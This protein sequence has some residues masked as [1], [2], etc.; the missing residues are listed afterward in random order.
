MTTTLTKEAAK[1]KLSQ[2]INDFEKIDMRNDDFVEEDTKQKLIQ[3]FFE[4]FNWNF[5][6][7]GRESEVKY[8]GSLFDKK[9]KRLKRVDYIFG[10][11]HFF[12]EAKAV[13]KNVDHEIFLLQANAYAYSKSKFCVLTDLEDFRLIRP[14]KPN[15]K[16]PELCIVE[17]YS[18]NY[19]DYL[20]KFDFLYETFSKEK[21]YEGSL[22]KLLE[23]ELKSKRYFTVDEYFL[24]DLENWRK[25]LAFDIYKKNKKEIGED[26]ELLTECTQRIL[27]RIIFS[28]ILEDKNIES[29][30]LEKHADKKDIYKS[31]QYEYDRLRKIYNGLI[32]NP[33]L[34]VDNLKVGDDILKDIIKELYNYDENDFSYNFDIIPIEILGSVY[35]RF[36]GN[37]I[38][39]NDKNKKP[40]H[41]K[42]KPN[43]KKAGGVFYTP[44]KIVKY[45]VENTVG[46]LFAK[47]SLQEVKSYKILDISCGSGS[48]LVGAYDFLLEWYKEYYE[49]N[50][51]RINKDDC[52]K[53]KSHRKNLDGK[54]EEKEELKLTRKKR[55]EILVDH[56]YGVDIDPQAV[57]V[58]QMSLYI[59]MLD[60]CPDIQRLIDLKE[61]ILPDLKSNIK[62]GNSLVE[63]KEK[64][65]G[66]EKPFDWDE[67]FPDV[68][69]YSDNY[70]KKILKEG[71]GFDCII[72]NPP[73]RKGSETE[74]DI[75]TREWLAFRSI[76]KQS[77]IYETI[78]GRWDLYIPFIEKSILLLK[79]GGFH[80]FV[81]EHSIELTPFAH[82]IRELLCI[83]N[84]LE[85]HFFP[86]Q[87]L[88]KNAKVV[89]TVY[90]CQKGENKKEHLKRFLHTEKSF[91]SFNI[92]PTSKKMNADQVFNYNYRPHVINDSIPLGVVFCVCAGA[93]LQSHEGKYRDEFTKDDLISDIK[94]GDFNQKYLEGDEIKDFLFKTIRFVAFK[95]NIE[96]IKRPRFEQL[97]YSPKLLLGC[98]SGGIVDMEN[99][100]VNH[101]VIILK[102]WIELKGLNNRSLS[103]YDKYFTKYDFTRIDSEKLSADFD[104]F[105]ILS[106]LMSDFG[107]SV[108][109]SISKSSRTLT[110]DTLKDFPLIPITPENKILYD[111]LS[112]HGRE[113][114]EFV[115][116]LKNVHV[117]YKIND[118]NEKINLRK[119]KNEEL[120]SRLYNPE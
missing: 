16:R 74:T 70:G 64:L 69:Q 72:G 78:E 111:S 61:L 92:L 11:K 118:L 79:D 21:I 13:E 41:V 35:E 39:I 60:D 82:K 7:M 32:F 38:E 91:Y 103:K 97:F 43:V 98:S 23:K 65:T 42:E 47:K 120:I 108:L 55:K 114:Q 73:Y 5:Q 29:E 119:K 106:I 4:C 117:D 44:D 49:S 10:D 105:S 30:I 1:E 116:E 53:V 46:K 90:I 9:S 20:S 77:G 45:I 31:L 102:R 104:Y 110:E 99:I 15:K 75:L 28:K 37:I 86:H 26:E 40:V 66:I 76:L 36:L 71:F 88:F 107:K 33:H 3:P 84:V 87:Q 58:S 52:I 50:P 93:Q 34:I 95:K 81:V 101:S 48:F 83:N 18:F 54:L 17:E 112:K 80:G 109:K 113:I 14:I 22:E 19:K 94:K 63:E 59:K 51:S 68:T 27:D 100:I 62:C 115:S 24:T 25:E 56:I 85:I 67:H 12:L 57:E 96:K 8:E 6:K 89:T 2:L